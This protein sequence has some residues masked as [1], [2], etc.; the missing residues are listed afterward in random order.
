ME[1]KFVERPVEDM[2]FLIILDFHLWSI[3]ML[4]I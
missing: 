1:W 4:L 3:N 2:D